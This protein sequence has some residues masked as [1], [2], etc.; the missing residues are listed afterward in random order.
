MASSNKD[1]DNA[2]KH[3]VEQKSTQDLL[4]IYQYEY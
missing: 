1:V 3:I 4:R 2:F